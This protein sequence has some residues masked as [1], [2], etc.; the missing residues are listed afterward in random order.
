LVLFAPS[1]VLFGIA[2]WSLYQRSGL[3]HSKHDAVWVSPT[4]PSCLGEA[5]LDD[6]DHKHF[7]NHCR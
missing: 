2:R 7:S 6:C 3:R 4:P 1:N 5:S